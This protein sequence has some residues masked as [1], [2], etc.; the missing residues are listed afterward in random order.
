MENLITLVKIIAVCIA[1]GLLGNWFFDE[2]KRA[3]RNGYPVYKA[4]YSMPGIIIIG[5]IVLLPILVWW[6]QK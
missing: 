3:K 1:A 6:V 5:I 2:V 4:Y